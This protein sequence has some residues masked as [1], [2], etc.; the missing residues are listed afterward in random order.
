MDGTASGKERP[1]VNVGTGAFLALACVLSA[2][3]A[4]AQSPG[5]ATFRILQRGQPVG[6]LDVSLTHDTEGWHI[7]STSRAAGTLQV[8][9]KRFDAHYDR[10]WRARFLTVERAGPGAA[11]LVHVAV[12]RATAHVDIVTAKEV[13]W[14]SHSISPDTVFLPDHAYGAFAA[15]AARLQAAGPRAEIP[16]LFVPDS[17][18]RAV[19]DAWESVMVDTPSG[20][21]RAGRH[22]LSVIGAVPTLLHVWVDRGNLVRVDIPDDEI[23]VIRSDVLA[24]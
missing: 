7:R 19:V 16:L 14:H 13:R 17:E 21:L 4:A 18:R 6:T 2:T 15:V 10:N 23:S 11:T 22:T 8:T 9:V 5:D 12:G 1:R 3:A 24:R 20:P